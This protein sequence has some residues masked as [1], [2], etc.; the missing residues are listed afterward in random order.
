MERTDRALLAA[1]LVAAVLGSIVQCLLANDGALF[2]AS[3]WLGDA[4]DLHFGQI[5]SRAFATYLSFGPAQM[6]LRALPLSAGAF[7][8]LSH[9]LYFAVPLMLW[10]TLRAVEPNRLFSRLYMAGVLALLFFPTELIVASGL[11]MICLAFATDPRRSTLQVVLVTAILGAALV[12]THP[13]VAMMSMLCVIVGCGLRMLRRPVPVRG[14]VVAA[15]LSAVLLAGY[16]VTSYALPPTN[17]TT[18]VALS[19]SGRMYLD[20]PWL[21]ASVGRY[22]ATAVLWFLLL[23][24]ALFGPLRSGFLVL[25]ALVGL[26]F[27]AAGTNLLTYVVVRYTAPYVLALAVTLAIAAPDAW[28][29]DAWRALVLYAAIAATAAVSYSADLFLLGRYVDGRMS[30]GIV[31]VETLAEPWPQPFR[32]YRQNSP[33]DVAFKW[34]AGPDYARD[35]VVPTYDWYRVMLAFYSYFRSGREGVLF[36]PAGAPGDWLPFECDS[37]QRAAA[38]A[39]DD[40]DRRFLDFIGANYCTR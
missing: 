11:W 38:R 13:A 9:A 3:G 17:G 40:T 10:L 18:A 37:V 19:A 34:G 32:P 4:W 8:T 2:I 21:A 39:R 35:V 14:L 29:K 22:P 33:V 31:N 12:F 23:G 24:P 6:A 5:P 28:L 16:L 25:L 26:W 30:P 36:H 20:I 7:V 27:A 1:F 15:A